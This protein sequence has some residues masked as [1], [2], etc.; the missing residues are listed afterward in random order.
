MSI[1]GLLGAR[2]RRI[3][4]PKLLRGEG[5]YVADLKL[6]G[7]VHV[8][9]VRSPLA[10]ARILRID[11]SPALQ[12]PGVVAVLTWESVRDAALFVPTTE[13][14]GFKAPEYPVLAA[15]KVHYA[16]QPVAVVVAEDP[17]VAADAAS[18]VEVEYDPL[19]PVLDVEEAKTDHVVLHETLGTNIAYSRI[20][21]GGD[22]DKVFA[23]AE[24]TIR[25]RFTLPRLAPVP[26]EGR[27]VIASYIR[28]PGPGSLAVW[29]STQVPHD[30]KRELAKALGIAANRLRVVAP[31]VGGGFGSKLNVYPEE[32]LVPFLAM[33]LGRPVKWVEERREGFT[34]TA[35]GRAQV[36]DLELA[37]T[38]DGR[39]LG[40][41]GMILADLGAYPLLTTPIVPPLTPRMLPGCYRIEALEVR[42]EM[43][44]TTA[45]PTGAYRGAGRPEAA[46]YIERLVDLLAREIGM[47][48]AEVRRRNFIS[49]E[50]FPYTTVTKLTYDSGNYAAA[51]Q[52]AL[53]VGEY[54]AWRRRQEELRKQGRHLG[55]GLS[56]YVEIC[57]FGPWEY[58]AVRVEADGT[59]CVYTGTSP[60]GQGAGTAL[61]QITAETLGVPIEKVAVI[62]GDTDLIPH[63]F[64]TGGSRTLAVGG[65][66]V[67]LAASRVR[68]KMVRIAAHLLEASPQDILLE[69]GRFYVAGSPDRAV[70]FQ[71]IVDAAYEGENLPEDMEPGLMAS[72]GFTP[73]GETYPFGAHLCVVEVDPETGGVEILRYVAVDDCGRVINPLLVQGQLHGGIAQAIGEALYE[74]VVYNEAG[75]LS[76]GTLAEYP[77]PKAT[78]VPSFTLDRTETPTALNPLGAK[79]I[80]EAGTIGATPAVVNAVLD[81]LTPFGVRHLDVPLWPEKVWRAIRESSRP[82]PPE[83]EGFNRPAHPLV[84][85][86]QEALRALG[87]QAEVI[88]FAESTRTAADAARAVGTTV[89]QIVKSLIF[90][91]GGEP[92]L[93]L[94]SGANRVNVEKLQGL[95]GVPIAKADAE[96]VRQVTGFSIGGVPPVGHRR[97]MRTFMDEDLLQFPEVWAAGG[98][99]NAVFKT[100]P[101]ELIRLTGATVADLKL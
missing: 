18:L 7:M 89:A 24:V 85:R 29:T 40:I 8:A 67:Y 19:L 63:G 50:A 25:Q 28:A 95:V 16:G 32:I 48:P 27:A 31:D 46:Y 81:A 87:S 44:Y 1:A 42:L 71:E 13:T 45:T 3:E 5:S 62:H 10:H 49:P 58:G 2:V 82:S 17:H 41:R 21:R 36:A 68:E 37:A 30:V 23:T 57:G 99:P 38:R 51:L 52:K 84:Q 15:E 77:I 78:Q 72:A 39:I 47:D 56:T 66:A 60:H 4:D 64:G 12:L 61:A 34:A 54:N 53:E 75:S 11:P 74:G 96:W 94:V 59:V 92:V 80:G 33:R 90:K 88:E 22:V 70:S 69:G 98:T 55:I 65:S 14:K 26:L 79:G 101:Q 93:V 97:P 91:A 6:P 20:F 83:H 9:F 86:V 35:H 100:S 73:E 43:V 76:T